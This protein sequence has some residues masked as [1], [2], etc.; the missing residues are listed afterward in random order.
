MLT[1]NKTNSFVNTI[2]RIPLSFSGNKAIPR[3]AR[4]SAHPRHYHCVFRF[5]T[6]EDTDNYLHGRSCCLRIRLTLSLMFKF[7]LLN[8]FNYVSFSFCKF[9]FCR[10]VNSRSS[11]SDFNSIATPLVGQRQFDW[12][13]R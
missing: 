6:Y 4:F 2:T 7:F 8:E 12:F 1:Y 11:G 10:I 5:K 9:I 13:E 3:S